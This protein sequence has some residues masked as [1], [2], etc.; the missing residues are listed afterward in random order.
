MPRKDGTGP[1]GRG[2]KTGRGLGNCQN[3]PENRKMNIGNRQNQ[4]SNNEN[5]NN[6]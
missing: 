5:R 6:K 2:P 4:A 3:I 1:I